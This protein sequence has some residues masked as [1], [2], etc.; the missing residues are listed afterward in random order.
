VSSKT[1][2]RLLTSTVTAVQQS[3]GR[4]LVS[5]LKAGLHSPFSRRLRL[6]VKGRRCGRVKEPKRRELGVWRLFLLVSVSNATISVAQIESERP[7]RPRSA[8]R[9]WD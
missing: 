5:I 4:L 7:W 9:G 2:A 6:I 3:R 8:F 1:L